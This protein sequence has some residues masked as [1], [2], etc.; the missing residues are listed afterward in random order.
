VGIQLGLRE[1]AAAP[2]AVFAVL[3]FG[4]YWLWLVA[5]PA[6]G[7][8]PRCLQSCFPCCWRLL[9]A[10]VG[11]GIWDAGTVRLRLSSPLLAALQLA[12]L[13]SERQVR[14]RPEIRAAVP[15]ELRVGMERH[16]LGDE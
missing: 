15:R 9:K 14:F 7:S 16:L 3:L 1:R 6:V 10:L 13:L 11:A 5:T 8:E 4:S 12:E 2:T